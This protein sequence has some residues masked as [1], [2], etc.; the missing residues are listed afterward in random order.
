MKQGLCY[1]VLN[2]I[3]QHYQLSLP[4]PH[5]NQMNWRVTQ[6]N[7]LGEWNFGWGDTKGMN[8]SYFSFCRNLQKA[9]EWRSCLCI[10]LVQS[11]ISH[12]ATRG[13]PSGCCGWVFYRFRAVGSGEIPR[14]D[15]GPTLSFWLQTMNKSSFRTAVVTSKGL[16]IIQVPCSTCFLHR[17]SW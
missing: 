10:S 13:V 14:C 9:W 4:L 2:M 16:A 1:K 11:D 17:A 12:V 8:C 6:V 5:I 15:W 3:L 7:I